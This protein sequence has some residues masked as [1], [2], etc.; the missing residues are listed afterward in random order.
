VTDGFDRPTAS[1]LLQA[2]REYLADEVVPATSG[3]ISFH[4]RVAA[5]V[6]AMIER[7]LALAPQLQEAQRRR[8]ESL[9]LESE[10]GFAAAIRNGT[11]DDRWSEALAAARADADDRLRIANPSYLEAPV[12]PSGWL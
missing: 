11:F 6:V 1:E 10:A 12:A 7:E 4:A 5:N 8:L 2:V 9:G 3:R